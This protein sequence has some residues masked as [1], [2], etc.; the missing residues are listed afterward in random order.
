M[1]IAAVRLQKDF[2]QEVKIGDAPV[3]T[4]VSIVVTSWVSSLGKASFKRVVSSFDRSYQVLYGI[5]KLED[6]SWNAE[7]LTGN[8]PVPVVEDCAAE[9]A[10]KAERARSL[11]CM[12]SE[13]NLTSER[14][15]RKG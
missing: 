4:V 10:A 15:C 14:T 3:E 9:T 13:V 8:V 5:V 1:Y 7:T 2:Y 12:V 11:N 6:G